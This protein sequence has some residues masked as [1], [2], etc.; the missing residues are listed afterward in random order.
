M[1]GP[2]TELYVWPFLLLAPI[3]L[4]LLRGLDRSVFRS[5]TR[6]HEPPLWGGAHIAALILF[7]FAANVFVGTVVVALAPALPT[8]EAQFLVL[9]CVLAILL[10]LVGSYLRASGQPLETLGF[11]GTH[12]FNFLVLPLFYI[13]SS[14]VLQPLCWGW[15]IVLEAFGALVRE[16]DVLQEFRA[17]VEAGDSRQVLMFA[18]TATVLAPVTEEILFRGVFFGGL[19]TRWGFF[20]AALASSVVFGGVHFSLSASFPLFLVGLILCYL[21]RRTGSIYPPIVYHAIFNGVT[22]AIVLLP[23]G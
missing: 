12:G 9:G 14:I 4:V 1:D 3:C 20:P 16:Q 2:V 21:Y 22:L 17:T 11:T 5:R 23:E 10:V 6:A 19:A 13:L 8:P 18:L 15:E 7:W